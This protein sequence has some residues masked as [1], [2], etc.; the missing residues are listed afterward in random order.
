MDISISGP[1][2]SGK[3]T[4][5]KK[6]SK[7]L[8]LKLYKEIVTDNKY[9][10]SFYKD[11]K[12]FVFRLEVYL[13]HM[14]KLQRKEISKSKVYKEYRGS[15][16]DRSI[17]EDRIFIDTLYEDNILSKDDYETLIDIYNEM[18][19]EIRG[20]DLLIYLEVSPETS[21]R[22][23]KFRGRQMEKELTIEYL[24]K[25]D[26]KY[27]EFHEEMKSKIPMIT[28]HWDTDSENIDLEAEKIADT[29]KK[30]YEKGFFRRIK[31]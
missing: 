4:L 25:L 16:S 1:I 24:K 30:E 3:T 22:R 15:V 7:Y 14:R 21:Y 19:T 31:I 10:E 8:G 18:L 27:K 13:M 29:I 9:L 11:M 5:A 28:V 23:Q 6:L 12:K 2:A 26:I 20:P 17:Y